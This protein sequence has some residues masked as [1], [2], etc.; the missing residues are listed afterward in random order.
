MH[1][2]NLTTIYLNSSAALYSKLSYN[3]IEKPQFVV[4]QKYYE[5]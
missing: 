2:Q 1:L 3:D 5:I 4:P